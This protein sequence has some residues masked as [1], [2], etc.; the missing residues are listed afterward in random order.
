MND[1]WILV[2]IENA[3]LKP[4]TVFCFPDVHDEIRGHWMF[5]NSVHKCVPDV[6]VAAAMLACWVRY[7]WLHLVNHMLTTVSRQPLI[8]GL[9][10]PTS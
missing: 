2:G 6:T 1:N 9:R 8:G 7:P 10:W 5:N 4:L 3:Y